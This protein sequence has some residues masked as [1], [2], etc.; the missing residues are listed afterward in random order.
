[1]TCTVTL[2][3]VNLA[4]IT[5]RGI[6]IEAFDP[7]ARSI[8]LKS[9]G[10]LPAGVVP[11]G[12][13]GALLGVTATDIYDIIVH[14]VGTGYGYA[15]PVLE[16]FSGHGSPQ[17]DIV[18]FSP[19]AAIAAGGTGA[20]PTTAVEVS[21]FIMGQPSWPDEAK[22]AILTVVSTISYLKR[23]VISSVYGSIRGDLE[24][25]M[26]RLGINPDLIS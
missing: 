15:P 10:L 5:A 1:M 18:L 13:Y 17:A 8:D 6:D 24:G 12:S 11:A 2:W 20:R 25:I 23:P 19:S 4:P 14:T 7:P 26:R 16:S 3:N 21:L 9:N 22:R